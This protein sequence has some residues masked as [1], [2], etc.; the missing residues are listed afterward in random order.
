MTTPS[1]ARAPLP[2]L[3]QSKAKP[4]LRDELLAR[5][6]GLDDTARRLADAAIAERVLAWCAAAGIASLGVYHP[7]RR[8]PDLLSAY[9]ALTA[10]GVHL[11]LPVVTDNNAPL[12]FRRWIPGDVL[13]K[14]ALGTL[15][16]TSTAAQVHPQALLV[17]CLGFSA[18]RYRLGYGGGFYDR[19]LAET[20]RPL[21]VGVCHAFGLVEFAGE[22]HDIA[23]DLVL[24]DQ[25]QWGRPDEIV[26]TQ[27]PSIIPSS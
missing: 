22:A 11:S 5:R 19:T 13:E 23:L 24:T 7:I 8:E 1:I 4:T 21:A 12:M 27:A 18:E 2:S 26:R 17:P 9:N 10:Q 3:P 20:P 25:G 14:D 6:R 16:P 15:T